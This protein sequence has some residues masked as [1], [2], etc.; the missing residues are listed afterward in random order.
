LENEA[1][2]ERLEIFFKA[3]CCKIRRAV[4]CIGGQRDIKDCYCCEDTKVFL[5][6][7]IL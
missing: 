4:D 6:K 1:E 3:L 5:F 7:K 2:K